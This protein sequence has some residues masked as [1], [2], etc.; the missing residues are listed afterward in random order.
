MT[1]AHC[2]IVELLICLPPSLL[3]RLLLTIWPTWQLP[4][5]KSVLG[6]LG[7]DNV[8]WP[9][10]DQQQ[11]CHQ[12]IWHVHIWFDLI[13]EFAMPFRFRLTSQD[14]RIY[15]SLHALPVQNHL[16]SHSAFIPAT[17]GLGMW[18]TYE[19][20]HYGTKTW[21]GS[22]WCPKLKQ[23]KGLD[24]HNQTLMIL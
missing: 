3:P 6:H 7:S 13:C 5:T 21:T 19:D 17:N 11:T 8:W 18:Y 22:S 1:F 24:G 4:A 23:H 14:V 9:W 12:Q 15:S 10:S 2:L 16:I 20:T